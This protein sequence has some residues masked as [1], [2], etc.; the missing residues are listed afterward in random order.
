MVCEPTVRVALEVP[1]NSIGAVAA[2]LARL[3][4][5][6]ET[7]SLHG[8]L[9]IVET[10]L[11]AAR[12]RDLRRQLAGLTHGEGVLESTFE[13]YEPVASEPPTRRRTT[14][15]PLNLDEYLAHLSRRSTSVTPARDGC[16]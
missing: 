11:P 1:A 12:A 7:P 16:S 13:G 10:V 3:G 9:A 5:A 2:E 14:P 4:A 8:E 6:A 15:N